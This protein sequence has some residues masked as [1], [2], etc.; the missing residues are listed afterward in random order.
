MASALKRIL[1]TECGQG[2][3]EY[4]L[5]LALV[6]VACFIGI[7]LLGSGT[8]NLY[9]NISNSTNGIGS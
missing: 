8:R 9:A 4:A 1:R 3:M 2:V 5:I 7:H 6:A